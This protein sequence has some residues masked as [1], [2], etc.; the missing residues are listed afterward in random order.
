MQRWGESLGEAFF[1]FTAIASFVGGLLGS[2]AGD[3]E[4]GPSMLRLSWVTDAQSR[5]IASRNLAL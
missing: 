2:A 3:E 5:G 1:L 4:A